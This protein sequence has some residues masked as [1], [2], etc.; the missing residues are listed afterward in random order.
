MQIQYLFILLASLPVL[1]I[2]WIFFREKI[3][4]SFPNSLMR[5][6]SKTPFF[7]IYMWILR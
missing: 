6:Y 4:Y 2:W 3:G 1:L 7:L 5:E